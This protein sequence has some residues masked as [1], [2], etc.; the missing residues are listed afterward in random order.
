MVKAAPTSPLEMAKADL[1][2]EFL[3][4][5]LNAPAQ[6]GDIDQL[7]ESN[8]RWKRRKPIFGRRS[9]ALRPLDQQ[10]F[11]RPALSEPVISMCRTNAHTRKTRRHPFCRPLTPPDLVPSMRGQPDRKLLDRDRVV[12]A[13]T[14]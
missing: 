13:I 9:F 1:P 2:F 14:P 10:P 8:V 12:F 7:T 11:L 4:V 6:L 3:V 5:A